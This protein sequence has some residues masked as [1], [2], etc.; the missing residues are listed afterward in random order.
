MSL[1]IPPTIADILEKYA[2]QSGLTVHQ[3]SFALG[4]GAVA[5]AGVGIYLSSSRKKGGT[6]YGPGPKGLPILGN[7]VDLPKT[8]DYKVYAQWAKKYGQ[9]SPI[10]YHVIVRSLTVSLPAG[11]FMYL[12]V[13]GQPIYLIS[14]TKVAGE[15]LDKRAMI[16]S[17]RPVM[18][19]AQDL[20]VLPTQSLTSTNI[21]YQRW[22]GT[23]SRSHLL[24]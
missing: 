23:Y 6:P 5:L 19:M 2:S 4:L 13:L 3:L 7:A 9:F 21:H 1:T 8:D 16:Y 22:M 10:S 15:L 18:V 24:L 14:S 17:D 12:T 20:F 11:D